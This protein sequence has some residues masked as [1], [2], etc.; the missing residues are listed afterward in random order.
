MC[1]SFGISNSYFIFVVYYFII[2]CISSYYSDRT[3]YIV[4]VVLV[5]VFNV[6]IQRTLVLQSVIRFWSEIVH[7]RKI[8]NCLVS[9]LTEA[10]RWY[11]TYLAT[12]LHQDTIAP[13]VATIHRLVL[14]VYFRMSTYKESKVRSATP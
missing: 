4:I 9:Y 3:R 8:Q 1:N 6:Y 2:T 7:E 11:D 13:V 14:L 10:P 5:L 12:L